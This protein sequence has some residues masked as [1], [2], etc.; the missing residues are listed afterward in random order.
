MKENHSI[1]FFIYKLELNRE[2]KKTV[3]CPEK[4]IEYNQYTNWN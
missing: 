4:L 3:L 1:N 2:R